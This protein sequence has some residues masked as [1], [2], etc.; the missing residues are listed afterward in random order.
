MGFQSVLFG[1]RGSLD[2]SKNPGVGGSREGSLRALPDLR[3]RTSVA[4]PRERRG[5]RPMQLSIFGFLCGS[6]VNYLA[7][8]SWTSRSASPHRVFA[9]SGNLFFPAFKPRAS[10]G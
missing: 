3:A 2:Q 6:V 7:V 8:S 10:R 5:S 4:Q 1:K 9:D